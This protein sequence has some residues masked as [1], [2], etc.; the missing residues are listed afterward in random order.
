MLTQGHIGASR[1]SP[2]SDYT[3]RALMMT[4]D[5][6]GSLTSRQ[7]VIALLAQSVAVAS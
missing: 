5:L 1:R 4:W 2:P 6:P 7:R 3:L